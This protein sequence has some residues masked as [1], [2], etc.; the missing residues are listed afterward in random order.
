M[1]VLMAHNRYLEGGGEDLSTRAEVEL[2]RAN[3]CEVELFERSNEDVAAIGAWRT[4]VKALWNQETYLDI[5]ARLASRR[6]DVMHIQNFFPLISPA[7]YYAA[8]RHGVPVVQSLRNYRLACPGGLLLRDDRICEDCVGKSVPWAGVR[9]RCYRQ[10]VPASAAVA[11]MISL[12]KLARTWSSKVDRYIALTAFMGAK[13]AQSGLPADKIAVKP[14]FVHPDP[15]PRG[16]AQ[17]HF[18]YVGRLS[19]EKGVD[20]L[21]D[22]WRRAATGVPLVIAGTG[23]L[24]QQLR[25]I[26]AN[27]PSVRFLGRQPIEKVYRHMGD[28]LALCFPSLWY[29]GM[30]RVI[31]E[32]FAVATPVISSRLG[33]MRE[34]IEDG[35]T[36]LLA[37]PGD[38]ESFADALRQAAAN[39]APM[40]EM[41]AKARAE[42]ERAYS[43]QANFHQLQTI[44]R[45]A[46]R[47][48]GAAS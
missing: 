42:F 16:N 32:A 23:P 43:G 2:L 21:V 33:S 30:P 46:K 36:G 22:A 6:Y 12:H 34:M 3:D 26:C 7:I 4:G 5:C 27:E 45:D 37:E 28:A 38:V 24:E 47:T 41:S 44:Y 20:I 9:N 31:I 14:N 15:G 19:K 40:A 48:C 1:R 35:C 10:S 17:S 11:G 8:R 39:R 29:E 25:E 18:L 13:L